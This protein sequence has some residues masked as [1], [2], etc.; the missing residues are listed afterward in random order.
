[1][2]IRLKLIE[3]WKLVRKK[4]SFIFNTIGTS[5][6]AYLTIAPDAIIQAW[7]FLPDDMKSFVPVK[8]SLYIPMILFVLGILSQYIKQQKLETERDKLIAKDGTT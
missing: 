3:D 8:Y 1:M 6:L 4:W 7:N 5:L 2:G